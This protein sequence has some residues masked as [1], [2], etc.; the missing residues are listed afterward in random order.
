MTK[1]PPSAVPAVLLGAFLVL[2]PGFLCAHPHMSLES[3]VEFEYS[4]AACTGFWL[5]WTFD[6]YF[7]AAIIQEHDR[8]GDGHFSAAEAAT[9]QERA[10]SNLR[11]YG[12]FVYLR[13]G[14][15]RRQP[16]EVRR[17]SPEI[18][19]DL[20]A[21]RF[22]IDLSGQGYGRDF[23]MAIFDP[24][25]YCAAAY[26]P[27]AALIRQVDTG[28]PA[29]QWERRVNKEYPVY[30][31]PLGTSTDMTSYNSWKPGLATAYPEEIRV[32][33]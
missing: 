1:E 21:Y 6:P 4:G 13:S 30:Y 28:A 25:Y 14:K 19:G 18:R 12:Y 23:S 3:R 26:Y 15:I 2:F 9:V 32:W 17:F 24:T 33:F 22:Y 16:Q 20:L 7:S 27:E 31:N 5:D 8:D 29:P 11:K 10:F